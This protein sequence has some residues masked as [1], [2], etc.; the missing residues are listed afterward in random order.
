MQVFLHVLH[1]IMHVRRFAFLLCGAGAL[2]M[3]R[4]LKALSSCCCTVLHL[5]HLVVLLSKAGGSAAKQT[6]QARKGTV[7][8]QASSLLQAA[9]F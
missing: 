8:P 7:F 9:C 5:P 6:T 4:I 1:F 2:W 3:N